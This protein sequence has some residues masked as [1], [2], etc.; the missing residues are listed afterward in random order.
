VPTLSNKEREIRA[1]IEARFQRS[2]LRNYHFEREAVLFKRKL[3]SSHSSE[4]EEYQHLKKLKLVD[5]K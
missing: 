1:A 5:L 4:C 2:K 3:S